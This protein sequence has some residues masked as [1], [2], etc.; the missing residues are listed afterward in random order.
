[1]NLGQ[2]FM[3]EK[4]QRIKEKQYDDYALPHAFNTPS[5]EISNMNGRERR[6]IRCGHI[7]KRNKLRGPVI[8]SSHL[9]F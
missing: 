7:E 4:A 1:M 6:F 3:A 2:N 8:P 9:G 5:R